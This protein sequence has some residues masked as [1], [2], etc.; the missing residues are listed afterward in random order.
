[1]KKL[2]VKNLNSKGAAPIFL[3][4]SV[5]VV[6]LAIA[7]GS[8][9]V[10][11]SELR[12]S[13]DSGE[14][15]AAYYAAETGVEQA[16]YDRTKLGEVPRGNRCAGNCPN[17]ACTDWGSDVCTENS[18]GPAVPYCIEIKL[19]AGGDPCNPGDIISIRSTGEN[20][21]TRRSIE[22]TF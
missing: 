19:K 7:L 3:V 15:V 17:P 13:L 11:S 12:T 2:L 18:L 22:A 20:K 10:V 21:I 1:M 6:V 14:S 16:L 9:Y 4:M 5:L 8:S